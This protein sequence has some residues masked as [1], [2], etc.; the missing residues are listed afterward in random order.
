M[1]TIH[2]KKHL[3]ASCLFL[4]GY[5]FFF[6]VHVAS[7]SYDHLASGIVES[8]PSINLDENYNDRLSNHGGEH[9]PKEN[10][11]SRKSR[12]TEESSVTSQGAEGPRD[13]GKWEPERK[14]KFERSVVGPESAGNA[15]GLIEKVEP[16]KTDAIIGRI[17]GDESIAE[18]V[19][20]GIESR[21]MLPKNKKD[22]KDRRKGEKNVE[23]ADEGTDSKDEDPSLRWSTSLKIPQT[24]ILKEL[25]KLKEALHLKNDKSDTENEGEIGDPK[26][27]D[28]DADDDSDEDED[29]DDEDDEDDAIA[30]PKEKVA[31][32][33]SIGEKK[34]ST[35]GSQN[36][37]EQEAL[38]GTLSLYQLITNVFL[39]VKTN[40]SNDRPQPWRAITSSQYSKQISKQEGPNL[41]HTS[42]ETKSKLSL[43]FGSDPV[44]A[45]VQEKKVDTPEAAEN[46]TKIE[47]TQIAEAKIEDT[48]ATKTNSSNEQSLLEMG[49][50]TAK[51]PVT[52]DIG[53]VA[54]ALEQPSMD[55][56]DAAYRNLDTAVLILTKTQDA[57]ELPAPKWWY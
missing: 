39:P 2:R 10:Y 52:L 11:H 32:K 17:V 14:R 12:S 20:L 57:H 45:Q 44:T 41:S 22:A 25:L 15:A 42:K 19:N 7:G 24:D 55:N 47:N 37:I 23:T 31:T 33:P 56:L 35:T 36:D 30:L 26:F 38:N 51:P 1:V 46:D 13:E 54:Q 40:C 16:E 4:L 27:D 18:D 43:I 53:P 21:M 49:T 34:E 50:T 28:D 6:L 3:A 29:D 48:E 8:E 5:S 9:S